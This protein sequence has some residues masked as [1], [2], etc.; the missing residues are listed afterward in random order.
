MQSQ[1]SE[2]YQLIFNLVKQIPVGKVTTYGIIAKLVGTG[3]SPRQIGYALNKA[4]LGGNVPAH[5]VVNRN[6]LLTG[7]HQFATPTLM[8]ELLEAEGLKILDNQVCDFEAH[9]WNPLKDENDL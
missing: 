3:C 6:G 4:S 9:L 1:L 2:T 7:R 5:R 8:Q